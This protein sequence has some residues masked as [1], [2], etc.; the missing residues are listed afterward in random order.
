MERL[1]EH[2]SL[3]HPGDIDDPPPPP[4]LPL[5]V[6]SPLP[7]AAL[8]PFQTAAGMAENCVSSW[9]SP[10]KAT[11]SASPRQSPSALMDGPSRPAAPPTAAVASAAAAAAAAA[12]V[13]SASCAGPSVAPAPFSADPSSLAAVPSPRRQSAPA[14]ESDAHDHPLAPPPPDHAATP[15]GAARPEGPVPPPLHGSAGSE[16]AQPA[17]LGGTKMSIRHVYKST[18]FAR[19]YQFAAGCL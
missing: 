13:D 15:A 2:A 12:S 9:P 17:L 10:F 4:T 19:E 11:S 7:P 1:H 5:A 3:S 18:C 8:P 6:A 14:P 16:M